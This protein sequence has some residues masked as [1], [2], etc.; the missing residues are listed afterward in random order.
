MGTRPVSFSGPVHQH[1]PVEETGRNWVLVASGAVVF[2]VWKLGQE[3]RPAGCFL[4]L[5]CS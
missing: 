1:S 5:L 3:S 4:I 2:S